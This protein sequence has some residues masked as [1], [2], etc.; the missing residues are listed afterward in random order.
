MWCC[1]FRARGNFWTRYRGQHPRFAKFSFPFVR[2]PVVFRRML[3]LD[4]ITEENLK[5][6]RPRFLI[7]HLVAWR[8]VSRDG[9]AVVRFGEFSKRHPVFYTVTAVIFG[10][11][12]TT[13]V[14]SKNKLFAS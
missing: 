11:A 5:T 3:P 1:S 8:T 4:C 2:V 13:A 12:V 14:L 6:G 7:D 10:A 9:K